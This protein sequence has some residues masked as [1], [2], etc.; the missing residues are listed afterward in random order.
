MKLFFLC[1]FEEY[2]LTDKIFFLI[3][4]KNS[5]TKPKSIFIPPNI[6]FDLC[7]VSSSKEIIEFE[8]WVNG[9]VS[10]MGHHFRK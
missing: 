5:Q 1:Q 6:F 7:G 9:E 10:K 4:R 2:V 3:E 8:N